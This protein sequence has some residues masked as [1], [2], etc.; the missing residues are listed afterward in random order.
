VRFRLTSVEATEVDDR[1]VELMAGAPDRLAPHLHAPLQSGSD[2]VLRR[3]GRHWYT[4]TSYAAAVDRVR[5]AVPGLALG[6]DVIA[7]FPGETPA[8]HAA[9][10][11]LAEAL[12]F[13]SLHVFPYSPR[14]GTAATRLG[15]PVPPDVARARA[16][17]LREIGARRAAEHRTRRSG[18]AADVVV[19]EAGLDGSRRGLTEDY[20]SVLLAEPRTPR[21]VRFPAELRL[22]GADLVA[23]PRP[24]SEPHA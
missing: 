7:G 19:L 6:A 5:A 8:D 17:E 16:R 10:V 1:L 14:P 21:G 11:A 2:R 20:L 12:P 24:S 4:S 13:T 23:H 18:G 9:T 15:D 3:M 22:R